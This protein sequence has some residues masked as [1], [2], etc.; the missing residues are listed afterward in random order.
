MEW[1]Q[2]GMDGCTQNH[3]H[4]HAHEGLDRVL[5]L[6]TNGTSSANISNGFRLH[7]GSADHFQRE[8]RRA[9]SKL[10]PAESDFF[11]FSKYFAG[12]IPTCGP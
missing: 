5:A 7:R 9:A 12:W 1:E 6:Q 11:F 8:R 3:T 4:T 2:A 10:P